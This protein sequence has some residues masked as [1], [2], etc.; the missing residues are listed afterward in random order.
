[1]TSSLRSSVDNDSVYI[2]LAG[3]FF[4]LTRVENLLW[5]NGA[6]ILV[7]PLLPSDATTRHHY[8]LSNNPD[9]ETLEEATLMSSLL[10]ELRCRLHRP[11]R[12]NTLSVGM[13]LD[14]RTCIPVD[15]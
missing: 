5:T 14:Q 7:H 15:P 1:M 6:V 11:F 13:R 10:T 9:L 8:S 2:S 4:W 12:R 3:Y